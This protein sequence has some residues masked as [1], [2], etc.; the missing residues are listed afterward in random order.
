M[1]KLGGNRL[2]MVVPSVRGVV[3]RGLCLE[4]AGAGRVSSEV[5]QTLHLAVVTRLLSQ[6]LRGDEAL[7]A[8]APPKETRAA[9]AARLRD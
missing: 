7:M 2:T 5:F 8:R 4:H 1:L 9:K 3:P 6:I